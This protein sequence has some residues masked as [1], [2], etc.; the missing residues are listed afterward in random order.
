MSSRLPLVVGL[1]W[2][3]TALALG[4]LGVI[5]R[6]RPPV[7]QLVLLGLCVALIA[8]YLC[9]RGF[10][11]WARQIDPLAIVALHLSR[12]VGFYFLVLGARGELPLAFATPAGWG[13]VFVASLAVVL[14]ISGSPATLQHRRLYLVWNALGLAD[15]LL[16][17]VTAARLGI[18]APDSM[19]ALLVLPL[20]LLPTFLV[21]LIIT[22]HLLLASVLRSSNRK[23]SYGKR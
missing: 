2:L 12:F 14:L 7:P 20:S 15:I 10:R 6:L 11:R 5:G 3:G 13:D 4:A 8:T 16:V 21:P 18:V 17:V 23:H 1:A 9:S 22:S 19:K